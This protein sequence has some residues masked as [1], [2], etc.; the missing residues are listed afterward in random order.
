MFF[1]VILTMECNLHCKYCF[2][3]ALKDVDAD[4]PDFEIDYFLPKKT[5][6]NI[7]SLDRFCRQDSNC[8]LTFYGGEPLL[9]IDEIK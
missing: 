9:Y 7:G 6:C 8:V 4:F 2:G 3:E 5:N 1:H